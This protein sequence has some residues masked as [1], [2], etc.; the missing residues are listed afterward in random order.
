MMTLIILKEKRP[1]L[2]AHF[3]SLHTLNTSRCKVNM[4]ILKKKIF[5]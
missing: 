1:I 2:V 3:I 5:F 4:K